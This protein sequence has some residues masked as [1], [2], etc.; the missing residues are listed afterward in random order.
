MVDYND[1]TLNLIEDNIIVLTAVAVNTFQGRRIIIDQD[2]DCL[3]EL[4]S[5]RLRDL[6]INKIQYIRYN[7]TLDLGDF[8]HFESNGLSGYLIKPNIEYTELIEKYKLLI[9]EGIGSYNF[10]DYDNLRTMYQL[11]DNVKKELK[12]ISEDLEK[13]YYSSHKAK[14]KVKKN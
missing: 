14:Q 6:G 4:I 7:S 9:L 12:T 1:V 10:L 11:D 3:K 8:I 13:D 5:D 2:I